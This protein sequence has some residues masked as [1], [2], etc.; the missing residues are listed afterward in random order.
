MSH[1]KSTRVDSMHA[2]RQSGSLHDD[3][4]AKSSKDIPRLS[5]CASLKFFVLKKSC[6][7]HSADQ[8]RA[9]QSRL[10][11]KICDICNASC[12]GYTCG[13]GN[14]NTVLG[15]ETHR[16]P[17]Q[18]QSQVDSVEDQRAS[19]LLEAALCPHHKR[20]QAQEH[21][22]ER[23]AA[24]PNTLRQTLTSRSCAMPCAG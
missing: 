11:L 14:G 23:P 1:N 9:F 15:G 4:D 13:D 3:L 10:H 5:I 7:T 12:H 19:L 6:K 24:A 2:L 22:E 18:V 8:S 17:G 20:S 21:I 16:H